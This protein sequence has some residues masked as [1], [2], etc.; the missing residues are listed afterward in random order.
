[1]MRMLMNM[2]KNMIVLMMM[3]RMMMNM[4][5][6]LKMMMKM[7]TVNV[8]KVKKMNNLIPFQIPELLQFG[9]FSQ[10]RAFI[11]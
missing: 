8:V 7:I 5:M 6:M 9:P 11:H 3:L 2:I 4:V 10:S 1:M